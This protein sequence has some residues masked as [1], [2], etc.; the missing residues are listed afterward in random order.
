MKKKL[1]IILNILV[2][3]IVICCLHYSKKYIIVNKYIYINILIILMLIALTI[4]N[5]KNLNIILSK[6]INF[7][8]IFL[9]LVAN[10]CIGLKYSFKPN[11]YEI[12]EEYKI[13]DKQRIVA[14]KY[15]NLL[16][17]NKYIWYEEEL[18]L[19]F[20]CSTE[21]G[22]LRDGDKFLY[23]DLHKSLIEKDYGFCKS[24]FKS[25]AELD[26]YEYVD[27]CKVRNR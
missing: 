25:I 12:I 5:K 11:G 23:E 26:G 17:N 13:S 20:I 9:L 15:D 27:H 24:K 19:G 7:I 8:I 16:F 4:I 2:N 10:L 22:S 18:P 21:I 3:I 6:I 1:L 14:I